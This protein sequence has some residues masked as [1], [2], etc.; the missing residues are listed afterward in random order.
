M[1]KKLKR[2]RRE[3]PGKI[4]AYRKRKNRE[5]GEYENIRKKK[6]LW[7]KVTLTAEQKEQIDSFFLEHYGRKIPHHWHRLYQ[8]YTGTFCADYFPEILFS[9]RLEWTVNNRAVA[10]FLGDKNLLERF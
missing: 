9:T 1:I 2:L 6:A 10:G 8:S 5:K 7:E 4:A 3:L